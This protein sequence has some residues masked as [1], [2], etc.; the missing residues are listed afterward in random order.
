M[1]DKSFLVNS[2]LCFK[3]SVSESLYSFFSFNIL[4]FNFSIPSPKEKS[5]VPFS[6]LFG[7]WYKNDIWFNLFIIF[8]SLSFCVLDS[9]ISFLGLIIDISVFESIS[10]IVS[11]LASIYSSFISF[12]V[13]GISNTFFSLISLMLIFPPSIP[14]SFVEGLLYIMDILSW[15][16]ISFFCD[17][18]TLD[19]LFIIDIDSLFSIS[20]HSGASPP[21]PI[22]C[23]SGFLL[24]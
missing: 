1:N 19:C 6:F 12:L 21:V 11:G 9:I 18:F 20:W 3:G 7:F 16:I 5:P 24:I 14:I 15:L 2:I 10:I 8:S 23:I 13:L 22:S 17:S 4:I